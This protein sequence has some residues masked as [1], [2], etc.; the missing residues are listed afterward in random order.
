M[1]AAMPSAKA[2]MQTV[3]SATTPCRK[4]TWLTRAHTVLNRSNVIA[5][6][7]SAVLCSAAWFAPSPAETRSQLL[8]PH[9]AFPEE[10][11]LQP[12]DDGGD[13]LAHADAH[14]G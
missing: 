6:D 9:D 12:L 10:M 8:A 3:A 4:D 7:P 1:P 5:P 2:P 14:S 13:A 11:S